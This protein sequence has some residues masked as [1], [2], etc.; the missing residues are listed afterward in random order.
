VTSGLKDV[1]EL[2]KE[3]GYTMGDEKDMK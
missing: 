2:N 3:A 1:F